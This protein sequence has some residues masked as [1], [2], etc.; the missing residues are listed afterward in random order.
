VLCKQNNFTALN[1]EI[2]VRLCLTVV[3]DIF[4]KGHRELR[5]EFFVASPPFYLHSL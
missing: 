4:R 1:L 3:I 5:V 2:C